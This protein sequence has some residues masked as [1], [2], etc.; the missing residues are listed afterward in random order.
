M[1]SQ[2]YW[3]ISL[4][5]A[6]VAVV[7]GAGDRCPLDYSPQLCD[8]SSNKSVSSNIVNFGRKPSDLGRDWGAHLSVGDSSSEDNRNS[9]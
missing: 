7:A 6:L 8:K 3:G 4:E 5:Q 2:S 9:L 1:L